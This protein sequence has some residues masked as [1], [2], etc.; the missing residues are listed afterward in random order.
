M[1]NTNFYWLSYAKKNIKYQNSLISEKD[2]KTESK[3]FQ[4]NPAVR[5]IYCIQY[6]VEQATLSQYYK[7]EEVTNSVRENQKPPKE[8]WKDHLSAAGVESV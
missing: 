6:R 2:C 3:A 1:K 8:R 5:G 4:H 7:S